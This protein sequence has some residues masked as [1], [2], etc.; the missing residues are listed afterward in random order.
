MLARHVGFFRAATPAFSIRSYSAMAGGNAYVKRLT[1]FK[2]PKEKDIDAVLKEYET[3][4][5]NALKVGPHLRSLATH[6]AGK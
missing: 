6:V 3:L 4:R 2:V 5:R 1:F